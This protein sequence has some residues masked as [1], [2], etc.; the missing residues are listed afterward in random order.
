MLTSESDMANEVRLTLRIPSRLWS[1]ITKQA[2]A[3]HRSLNQ[4]IVYVLDQ[5]VREAGQAKTAQ[6]PGDQGAVAAA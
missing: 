1:K 4:H 5:E 2:K 6:Q 3:E